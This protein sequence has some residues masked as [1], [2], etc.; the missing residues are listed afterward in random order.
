M[1]ILLVEENPGDVA[2]VREAL[3]EQPRGVQLR[4]VSNGWDALTFLRHQESYA[5]APVPALVL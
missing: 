3:K 5:D 2:L 4:V 1:Q